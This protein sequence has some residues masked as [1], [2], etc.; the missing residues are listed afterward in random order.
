[1]N[2]ATVDFAAAA[3]SLPAAAVKNRQN[4]RFAAYFALL[5]LDFLAIAVGF[6]IPHYIYTRGFE[7]THGVMMLA[8]LAP[9]YS[10]IAIIN[11]AYAADVLS[12]PITGV[13]RALQSFA[14]AAGSLLLIA[15]AF[16]A[17][18]DFS[19]LVF[20][21]GVA[22]TAVLIIAGRL[23]TG[24]PILTYLGGTSHTAVVICDGV[25]Y[26]PTSGEIVIVPAAVGF[27][28]TTE[29]P[30]IFDAFAQVVSKADRIVVACPADRYALWS[31]VLK[32]MAVK[33]EIISDEQ[34]DLGILSLSWYRDHRT[35]VVA[36]G[37]L[38]LRDRIL[39]RA[40]DLMLSIAGLIILSPVL[41]AV[42]IAIKAESKGAVFFMQSRVGRD[43]KLF[44]MFK[45]RSMYTDMC[46]ASA[47]QLTTRNDSRVTRVG[48][49][50]RRTSI[51]ELPQLFNVIKG[52]MSI[53][54]PRPHPLSA[55][56]ADQL[57]WHVD[58]SYRH[59]H[60]MKPGITGL[61]QIRGF[62]GNTEKTEDLT[63]RLQSD[64][65]Y[66]SQWSIWRDIGIIFQTFP[67]IRHSN[68]F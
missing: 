28:P 39:K 37:S 53:V 5:L 2:V 8:V 14:F 19:R 17:G 20:G 35:M 21:S 63:N 23:L 67:V 40:L 31:S 48:N 32:G 3:E 11:R 59:R 16:K 42:A 34:I 12:R 41:L 1:M 24:R 22:L 61:A 7:A 26:Q 68:A 65:E 10:G 55:K 43:N 13:F 60:S 15:Y 25:T 62:R 49:F 18:A 6:L 50:I 44:R 46:D 38:A 47:V 30:Y 4:R 27:D 66:L 33:G 52:D 54:G 58:P 64:L 29:D 45:F 36:A 57:Y 9:I 56:A 51:D